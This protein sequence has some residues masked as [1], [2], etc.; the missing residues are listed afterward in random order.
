MQDIVC[1][2]KFLWKHIAD[3]NGGHLQK[4][5]HNIYDYEEHQT[6]LPEFKAASHKWAKT[7][8]NKQAECVPSEDSDQPGHPPSL[9]RVWS[10]SSLCAQWV[11]KDL[12]FLHADSEDSDL[13]G[14]MPRLI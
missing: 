6:N 10:E 9:I 3:E 11:A 7:W 13:T 5:N 4:L 14:R 2:C 12:S 1:F 8:Q